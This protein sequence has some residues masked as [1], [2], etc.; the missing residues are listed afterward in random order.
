MV[1]YLRKEN[2]EK[3]I[4]SGLVTISGVGIVIKD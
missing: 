2:D 3:E 4:V 1:K